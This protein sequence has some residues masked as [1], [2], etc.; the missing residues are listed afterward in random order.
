MAFYGSAASFLEAAS[1]GTAFS[2][3][4]QETIERFLASA[5]RKFDS[6][7][8]NRGYT[9]ALADY[10]DDLEMSIY[11]VARWELLV[12]VGVNPADPAHAALAKA[13][14]DAISWWK[15][16]A[17]GWANL[18]GGVTPRVAAGV[19]SVYSDE[20]ESGGNTTRGW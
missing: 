10:G 12:S 16:I 11:N 1:T 9:S 14:D 20:D 2:D 6:Y 7:T 19:I 18:G 13:H 17:K 15:D 5:S 8:G 3:I 4:P